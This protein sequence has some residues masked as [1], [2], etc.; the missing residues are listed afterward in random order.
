VLQKNPLLKKIFQQAKI[1]YEA[2]LTISQISF[3]KKSQVDNHIIMVGDAA[4]MIT[5]LCGN[6]MSMALHGSK[7]AA[8]LTIQFLLG[9]LSRQQL[10]DEYVQ[11]WNRLFRR[12]LI[13][14]RL[15]QQLFGREWTTNL[16]LGLMKPFPKFVSYLIRQTHGEP[17]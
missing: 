6:G 9:T 4:G 7:I 8:E 3:E 1:L 11:Q 15:I 13:A 17:F 5:P 10:E 12:R 14:G 16:F 2:P